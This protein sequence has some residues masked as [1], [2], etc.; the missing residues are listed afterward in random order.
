MILINSSSRDGMKMLQPFFPVTVPLGIGYLMAVAEREGIHVEL[1][2]EQIENDVIEAVKNH[3]K[4]M[5]RPHIF[6]F[7]VLTAALKNSIDV[8]KKLKELYPD[9]MIIFGGIHPSALPEEVL[10]HAHIDLVVMGEGETA[11]TELYRHIKE[12]RDFRHLENIAYMH[13]GKIIKNKRAMPIEDIDKMPSF[14]YHRFNEKKY[15]LG[16]VMT[17]RGC[18]YDCI[19]CSNRVVTG[20]RYR[21]RSTKSVMDDLDT[22]YHRYGKKHIA[23]WDD[24]LLV[25]KDRI[26]NLL[27]EIRKAGFNK[28]V[29]FTFQARA[30]NVDNVI[31][32]DLFNAGFESIFFGIETSSNRLMKIL[33]K[34]ESLE[35]CRRA[36]AMAKDIGFIVGATFIYGIPGETHKERMDC[37]KLTKELGLDMVRYNNATPYPGTEL[38]EIAKREGR[39]NVKGLYENFNSVACFVENP[40]RKSPLSYVPLNHS[41]NDIRMDILLSYLLFYLN[42]N[43]IAKILIKRDRL[44]WF[45]AGS[46]PME[47][48]KKAPYI[49]FLAI[50]MLIKFWQLFLYIASKNTKK[51]L[52][53]KSARK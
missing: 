32:K 8:S 26:Y 18:P 11:I 36:V 4:N 30:D 7:S 47:K 44:G 52:W 3:V 14:P 22:I 46:N 5:K 31:L 20:K 24:N 37:V 12:G 17:S 39:L 25:S 53:F 48:I 19:F 35:D 16:I 9:S 27:S 43:K 13:D 29:T 51:A 2:D 42:I 38:F 15:D 50:M 45:N 40:F 41:E 34:G 1:I 49:V 33:K 10:S 28:K 21:F 6:G 23:F